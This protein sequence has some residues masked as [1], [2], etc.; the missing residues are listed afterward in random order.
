MFDRDLRF[1]VADGTGLG[2]HGLSS[3]RMVGT[4]LY[5]VF[6]YDVI[7][8]VESQYQDVFR[9]LAGTRKVD[10]GGRD[11]PVAGGG[12]PRRRRHLWGMGVTLDVTES[13]QAERT[14]RES[15]RRLRDV[16]QNI[17]LLA[18]IT[19][20]DGRILYVNRALSELT[21]QDRGGAA[22]VPLGARSCPP[23]RTPT[24]SSTSTLSCAR[25]ASSATTRTRSAG[26]TATPG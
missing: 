18:T 14:L 11:L 4:T 24:S 22:R 5:D 23:T 20:V 25:G 21:G 7:A 17:D 15:E 19:D 16:L 8:Q 3:D 1:D 10:W 6:P 9:G 26:P 2:Y 13:E 12:A